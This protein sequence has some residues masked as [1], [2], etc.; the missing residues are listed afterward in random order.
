[1]ARDVYATAAKLKALTESPNPHEAARAREKYHAFA[2][3]YGVPDRI[4][5]WTT[6]LLSF[7]G[8]REQALRECERRLLVVVAAARFSSP[9]EADQ[10][11]VE[12]LRRLS[13]TKQDV[14][15]GQY[16]PEKQADYRRRFEEWRRSKGGAS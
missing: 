10:L 6:L 15:L 13:S 5:A 1:M 11:E 16:P 14:F 3:R 7:A 4:R 9:A 2:T 12:Y 8:Q